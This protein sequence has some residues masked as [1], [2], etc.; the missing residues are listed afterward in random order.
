MFQVKERLLELQEE[1]APYTPNIIAVTKYFGYDGIVEAHKAGL[2]NFGESRIPE[3][4]DKIKSLPKE[5]QESS[6]FHMI[7]HLQ[8]NKV[9]KVVEEHIK[10]G[11]VVAEYSK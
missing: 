1:I 4:I 6:K 5:I 10:G 8:S 11:K 9:K 3:A 2:R 7:G